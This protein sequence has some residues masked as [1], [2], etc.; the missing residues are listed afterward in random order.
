MTS[1]RDAG[2][3][4]HVAKRCALGAQMQLAGCSSLK[5]GRMPGSSSICHKALA[6]EESSRM[7]RF[8]CSL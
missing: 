2:V 4:S 7:E 5:S 1:L 3:G 8:F 6:W